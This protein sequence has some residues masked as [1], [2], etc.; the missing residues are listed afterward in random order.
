MEPRRPDD[1]TPFAL[2]AAVGRWRARLARGG[3]LHG[4]ELDELEAHLWDV[5]EARTA[6]GE[7]AAEAFEAAVW[8]LGHERLLESEFR[9]T[10]AAET[11]TRASFAQR[12]LWTFAMLKN[13]VKITLRNVRRYPGYAFLNVSG[14]ALGIAA[15]LVIFVY[16]R[17]ELTYDRFHTEAN[18]IYQ[19]YKERITPAGTQITRDTWVPM[20]ERLRREYPAVEHAVR[21]W[22]STQWVRHGDAR[23]E[24]DVTFTDA[25]LWDVFDFPLAQG[26][27]AT[28]FRDPYSAV[29]SQEIARKYFGDEDPI[30]KT[31]TLHHTHDYRITGVLAPVPTNATVRIDVAAPFVSLP[32][33]DQVADYWDGS[34]IET[35]VLLKPGADPAALEAQFPDL[36]S[37][38]W[39]A[40]E[41]S[42]T[43]FRLE[44]L[45]DLWNALTG[46]RAYAL[47]LVGVALAILLIAAINFTNL[48]TARS[49]QRAREI[50]MR[51]VL[52]ARRRQLVGQF[53]GESLLL[54]AGALGLGLVLAVATL[55]QLERLYDIE[56]S[57][58]TSPLIPVLLVGLGLVV[59]LLAGAY[60]A[61]VLSGFRPIAALHGLLGRG[62]SGRGLRHGLVVLQFTLAAALI[63][64]TLLVRS[65]VDF[66]Q[67]ADLR[68]DRDHL[69]AVRTDLGDFAD[70]DTARLHLET[71]R[72]ALLQTG[73]VTAV[74]A[75]SH[76]PGDWGDAFTF[77]WPGDGGDEDRLRMRRAFVD[78]QYFATYGID[79]VEGRAFDA[80]RPTDREDAVILN[81]AALRAFGWTTA[82]GK[83]IRRG[84]ERYDVVGV[85]RDYHYTSL[86]DEIAPVLHFYRP[87]GDGVHNYV[88]ARLGTPDASAALVAMEVA[89]RKVDPSR[90]LP[91]VFVDDRFTQL[92][93]AEE[94]LGTAAG[95]FTLLAILIACLG[96][97][98]LAS[99]MVTQRVKEIGIRKAL[100]ASVAG[101]VLLV[102]KE[103]ARLVLVAVVLAV[104]LA[105][106]GVD[107]W[108]NHFAYRIEVADHA[109]VFVL[110]GLA[111]LLFAA[112]TVGYQAVRAALTDPVK[113]LRYE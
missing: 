28:A 50:G 79:L 8:Q 61:F 10:H 60:P 74:A 48:A 24:E 77:A 110:A 22:T 72:H 99:W 63:M 80:N 32:F 30:G 52:G 35:Y 81:E 16:A 40:E 27:P 84:D 59:G 46:N 2:D 113:A 18:R 112:A 44:A 98:G 54:T 12:T 92:Y 5:V 107:A 73:G 1:L 11:F 97:F 64:A 47:I 25:A 55:P 102:T 76:L 71:F 65:Q 69:V 94:R 93:E 21:V 6:A 38:L 29:V 51:K 15:S 17:H 42:R 95:A 56:L 82:E 23:F 96:L 87:S 49:M 85:V 86:Q 14:L 78:D 57:L 3:T 9:K 58:M 37:R 109:A 66:M 90:A 101:I 88:T 33:Y 34:F 36:I 104:P 111:A 26:D 7:P 20:A 41:A 43:N 39:N 31:L 45:P 70:A 68:F 91:Y 105:Y 108:L 75:A 62:R 67:H 83:T 13:Y 53:L 89:W 100:G 103:F 4:D 19:V 106:L